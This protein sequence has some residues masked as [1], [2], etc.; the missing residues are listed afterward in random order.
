LTIAGKPKEHTPWERDP[1]FIN[2]LIVGCAERWADGVWSRE[3]AWWYATGVAAVARI[4]D[5]VWKEF[6]AVFHGG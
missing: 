6:V 4:P 3:E 2:E 1:A 5:A